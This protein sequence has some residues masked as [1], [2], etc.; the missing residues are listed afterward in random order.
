MYQAK[1]VKLEEQKRL[2]DQMQEMLKAHLVP[3]SKLAT[4][5]LQ[6]AIA[7]S[8]K[9]GHFDYYQPSADVQNIESNKSLN[10]LAKRISGVH[11]ELE[12]MTEE[13]NAA[14]A[15][16]RSGQNKMSTIEDSTMGL[17]GWFETFGRPEPVPGQDSLLS[18]FAPASK[19]YGGTSHH[20]SFKTSA[21]TMKRGTLTR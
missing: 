14:E 16:K 17:D 4:K 8:K 10:S 7:V 18:K 11:K 1:I 20:K 9:P 21:M 15:A 5:N 19:I 12:A 3:G 2:A 13:I 6:A